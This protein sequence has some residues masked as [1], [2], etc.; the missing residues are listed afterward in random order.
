MKNGGT[1]K[2]VMTAHNTADVTL[3]S[4]PANMLPARQWR[5]AERWR[6]ART[7]K[8]KDSATHSRTI[9]RSTANSEG[10]RQPH[11]MPSLNS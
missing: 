10:V 6:T 5:P 11:G 8:I 7:L 3:A 1:P 2:A 9:T 4:A